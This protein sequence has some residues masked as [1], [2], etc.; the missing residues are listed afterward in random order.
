MI[1]DGKNIAEEILSD[2]AHEREGLQNELKLGIV[3]TGGDRVIDSF[4]RIK[5]RLA[6]RLNVTLVREE[7]PSGATTE[8]AVAA[9]SRLAGTCNG[10]IVQLPLPATIETEKVLA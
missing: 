1:I 5:E 3:M 7:L 10:I 8:D 9:V 6:H 4:V 2:L